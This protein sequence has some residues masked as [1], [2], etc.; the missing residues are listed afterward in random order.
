MAQAPAEWSD[1]RVL[2]ALARG[3]SMVAAAKVLGIEHTTVGRRLDAL[4]KALGARLVTRS[5]TGVVLTDAGKQAVC[6]AESMEQAHE[7]LVRN[8]ARATDAPEGRVRVSLTD[9]FVSV[10]TPLLPGL[11]EA[12]PGID[13]DLIGTSAVVSL[14][15]GE[16]DIA[17]RMTR[18]KQPFLVAKKIC[19]VG[20]SLYASREYVAK[21]GTPASTSS[22]EGHDVLGFDATIATSQGAL[23]L[24]AKER[25]GRVVAR[26]NTVALLGSLIGAGIGIGILPCFLD[27][28]FVRLT[29]EVLA[30][31][32][33]CAVVHEDL[34]DV[35]RVRSV[36]DH[37]VEA[38]LGVRAR[39][40]GEG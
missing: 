19:D 2:L 24:D 36:R 22:F 17:L 39:L 34:R 12:L 10:V 7:A 1:L 29:P 20:W 5:R 30:R 40:S 37:L 15:K 6:A 14:E 27:A 26:A 16:A 23:W 25:G 9:G 11:R 33:L 3:G 38:L 32:E 4:E 8:V 18:P 13:V 28:D 31:S 35:P 21:R